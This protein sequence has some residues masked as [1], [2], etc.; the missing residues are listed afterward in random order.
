[1]VSNKKIG[2]PAVFAL[3]LFAV[4][5]FPG[6]AFAQSGKYVFDERNVLSSDDFNQLESKAAEYADKYHIGAYLLFTDHLGD[7]E[8]SADGR[9][10]FAR[11]YFT[12][13][14]LGASPNGDG[15]ILTVAVDGRKYVTVKHFS[16]SSRDPFSNDSAKAIESEVKSYLKDDE[17]SEAAK[18][19]YSTV[20]EHMA[21]FADH[22]KQWTEPH[23]VGTIIKGAATVL[24]PLM[25]AFGI[26]SS[27]RNA[28]KTARM[29]TEANNYLDTDT[30]NLR[31]SNDIF[32][33]RTISAVPIPHS[34][35]SD[36][37]SDSGWSDMGGGFS[38][39]DGGDF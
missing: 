31:T 20:G 38:G 34:D 14:D 2:L 18:T 13:H 17:W 35:D 22:G 27:E 4:L 29:Q 32:V 25:I 23:I 28:M 30:F 36:S 11:Q 26:V 7:D 24:M 16:D 12:Q 1:M 39:T 37:G 3:V 5:A 6:T 9:R 19:Y 8:G 15:I 10:E 33:D 21:Y